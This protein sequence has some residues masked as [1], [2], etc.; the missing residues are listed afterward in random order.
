MGNIRIVL[1][2]SIYPFQTFFQ[3]VYSVILWIYG[4]IYSVNLHI[5]YGVIFLIFTW[6][7]L[8]EFRL[9]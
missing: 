1:N 3:F 8:F 9:T 7:I 5:I 4:V 6:Q 2:G